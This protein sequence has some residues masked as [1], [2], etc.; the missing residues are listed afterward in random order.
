MVLLR[1]GTSMGNLATFATETNFDFLPT[2]SA[3]FL[4]FL[5]YKLQG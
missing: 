1:P 5:H 3:D 4:L 2:L